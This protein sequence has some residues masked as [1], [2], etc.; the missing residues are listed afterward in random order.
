MELTLKT[1]FGTLTGIF[2]QE[3]NGNYS[4]WFKEKPYIVAQGKNINEAIDNL[5]EAIDV[6]KEIYI[7]KN[8]K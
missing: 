8:G 6:F 1:R 4:S 3:I 2:E 7:W 5:Y